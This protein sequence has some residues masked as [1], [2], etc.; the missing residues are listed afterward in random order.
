MEQ[1]KAIQDAVERIPE[2]AVGRV[3]TQQVLSPNQTNRRWEILL[4]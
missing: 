1:R 3:Q 2:R 4:T